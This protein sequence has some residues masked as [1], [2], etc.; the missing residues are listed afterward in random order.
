ML[1]SRKTPIASVA[2]TQRVSVGAKQLASL[3]VMLEECLS[4]GELPCLFRIR[5][6]MWKFSGQAGLVTW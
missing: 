4:P 3:Q 5:N 2:Y 6:S 1:T